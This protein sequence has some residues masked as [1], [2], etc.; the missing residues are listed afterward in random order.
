[1]I[2]GRQGI[3]ATPHLNGCGK[4]GKTPQSPATSKLSM[5]K[6]PTEFVVMLSFSKNIE[7]LHGRIRNPKIDAPSNLELITL[8]D[9]ALPSE[10]SGF[11]QFPF[12]CT[13]WCFMMRFYDFLD[14]RYHG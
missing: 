12:L 8:K 14:E 13:D 5:E 11:F 10:Q 9:P 2:I 7:I 6:K 4:M 3:S 1:M